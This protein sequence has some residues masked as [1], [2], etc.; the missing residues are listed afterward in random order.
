MYEPSH[1]YSQL[2]IHGSAPIP[3]AVGVIVVVFPQFSPS[4][5]LH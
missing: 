3:A 2:G 1:H 4:I 5:Y